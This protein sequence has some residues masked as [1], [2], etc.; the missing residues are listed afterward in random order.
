MKSKRTPSLDL[1][2]IMPLLMGVWRRFQKQS[3]PKD[4]LQTREF[5]SVVD[6]VKKLIK[7]QDSDEN[8]L[9]KDYFVD[10]NLL[11]AYLLY[12]FVI[13]YQQGMSL[14]GELPTTPKRVLDVCSGPGAFAFAALR[15]GAE[16]VFATDQSTTALSLASEVCGRYGLSV[17]IRHWDCLKSPL[18]IDGKFDLITLGHSL[19]ELFPNTKKGWPDDQYRFIKMLL[20]RLTPQGYLMLV[21]DSFET[22]NRRVL[23]LRDRLVLE[24]V[25]VQAPCIWRGNCPSLKTQKSPCYAQRELNKPYLIREIQRGADIKL[26]SL[27]MTYMIFKNPESQWPE[28]PEGNFYR[29]ISPPVDVQQSKRFYICGTD[30][31]KILES[32]LKE[33]PEEARAFEYL[34]RGEAISIEGAEE[35]LN[36]FDVEENTK[37]KVIA[38]CGKPLND[39]N[40]DYSEY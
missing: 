31:K 6:C 16:E 19:E 26:G 36:T 18:P 8:P 4:A 9:P 32:R 3:G 40:S 13:N 28:L 17:T 24:G 21:E 23:E 27:K 20:E 37:L 25:P 30:G 2:T 39:I 29:I 14:I 35:K 12:Q 10:R 1:E 11:G 38:A 33:L 22:A 7:M 34:R 15:H 5:R